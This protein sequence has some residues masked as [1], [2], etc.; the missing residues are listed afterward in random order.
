MLHLVHLIYHTGIGNKGTTLRKH[1]S[2]HSYIDN[3]A[4]GGNVYKI[5]SVTSS[6]IYSDTAETYVYV[7]LNFP[8]LSTTEKRVELM[9]RNT[10]SDL[11]VN[12]DNRA[13][14]VFVQGS[15]IFAFCAMSI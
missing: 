1:Q 6:D 3:T 12:I 11:N 4:Q 7:D 8:I 15:L 9:Y 14:K 10:L 13:T 2:S 5:R